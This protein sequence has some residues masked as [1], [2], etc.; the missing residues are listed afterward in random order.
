[1][2]FDS[3]I[4]LCQTARFV[5]VVFPDGN[6]SLVTAS[7]SAS[8]EKAGYFYEIG[9]TEEED[10]VIRKSDV[11]KAVAD[12]KG[13]NMTV[14][15]RDTEPEVGEKWIE[16][17]GDSYVPREATVFFLGLVTLDPDKLLAK[18]AATAKA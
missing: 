9:A 2:K 4:T 18:A 10:F 1:M 13:L 15:V 14:L 5:N 17:N 3:F 6:D 8:N 7:V 16:Y 11:A 12:G